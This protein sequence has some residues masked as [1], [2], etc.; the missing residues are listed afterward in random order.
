MAENK[1]EETKYPEQKSPI[2]A[3]MILIGLAFVGV[4]IAFYAINNLNLRLGQSEPTPQPTEKKE[5]VIKSPE[6]TVNE[7]YTWYFD[8]IESQG[9]PLVNDAYMESD[10]LSKGFKTEVKQTLESF[11][12]GGF[13][14]FLCAQDV[15]PEFETGKADI[16]GSKARVDLEQVFPTGK[17]LIPVELEKINGQWLITNVVCPDAESQQEN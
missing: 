13:D 1:K 7:F 14:P 5:Q 2:T 8:Y 12:G 11:D 3:V 17:R 15:P 6:E 4:A 9:N 16:D 10:L